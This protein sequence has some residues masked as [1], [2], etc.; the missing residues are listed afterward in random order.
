MTSNSLTSAARRGARGFAPVGACG[1]APV[2]GACLAL[3]PVAARA[4]EVPSHDPRVC[5]TAASTIAFDL[6]AYRGGYLVT[7]ADGSLLGH[8][9]WQACKAQSKDEKPWN[10]CNFSLCDLSDGGYVLRFADAPAA[11]AFTFRARGG[12]LDMTAS[13]AGVQNGN[14]GVDATGSRKPVAVDLQ[15]Y[16]LDWSIAHWPG[17]FHGGET[18]G[19]AVHESGRL[20]FSMYPGGPYALSIAGAH[21]GLTVSEAGAVSIAPAGGA[22]AVR[23]NAAWLRVGPVAITPPDGAAWSIG[24]ATYQGPQTISLPAGATLAL[25]RDGGSEQALTLDAGC[26]PSTGAG[27]FKVALAPGTDLA[28]TCS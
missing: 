10:S 27:A 20:I 5:A 1:F 17:P 28:K 14:Y 6:G 16:A 22:L 7:H 13:A 3:L 25:Q 2:V 4:Q 26:H 12:M 24:G 19:R 21:A 9:G 23:G 8:D 11:P 18:H 15:G